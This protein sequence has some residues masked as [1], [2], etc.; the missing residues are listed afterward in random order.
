MP[1]DTP[2]R[3]EQSIHHSS[4]NF[5]IAAMHVGAE[6]SEKERTGAGIWLT[7]I[8]NDQTKMSLDHK[9]DRLDKIFYTN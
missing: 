3:H 9:T 5:T 6:G 7:T 2:H 8:Y 1:V 4:P